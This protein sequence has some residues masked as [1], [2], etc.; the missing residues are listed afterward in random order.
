MHQYLMSAQL[1]S[2]LQRVPKVLQCPAKNFNVQSAA[3]VWL[4]DSPPSTA[5]MAKESGLVYADARAM[6]QL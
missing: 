6:A 5:L 2:P 4:P 3:R 1:Q